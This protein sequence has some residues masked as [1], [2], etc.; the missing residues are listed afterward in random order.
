[1]RSDDYK[2]QNY[3]VGIIDVMGQSNALEGLSDI[4][5]IDH[6]SS[7]V[8]AARAAVGNVLI[9]RNAVQTFFES[10]NAYKLSP[11]VQGLSADQQ[12]EYR[13]LR[14]SKLNI[15]QFSDT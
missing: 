5:D 15:Q 10:F 9:V 8:E 7:Y 11:K 3:V 4:P 6:R 12:A 1:M 13:S 2:F 14:G